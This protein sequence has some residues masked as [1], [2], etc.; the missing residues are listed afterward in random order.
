MRS[1][2]ADA[3]ARLAG[4]QAA[5]RGA[6]KTGLARAFGTGA[7]YADQDSQQAPPNGDDTRPPPDEARAEAFAAEAVGR[8][9]G[10]DKLARRDWDGDALAADPAAAMMSVWFA[11]RG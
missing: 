9:L 4:G 6:V 8:A 2:L 3:R 1:A 10:L 7:L 11:P 5:T